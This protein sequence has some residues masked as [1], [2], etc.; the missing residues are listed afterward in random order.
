MSPGTV[1]SSISTAIGALLLVGVGASSAPAQTATASTPDIPAISLR[2]GLAGATGIE[3]VVITVGRSTVLQ[4]PFDVGRVALTNP[5][6]ADATVVNPRS[7]LLDGKTPGTIS[8]IL[9]GIDDSDKLQYDLV[10]EPVMSS[11]QERLRQ[12][13]PGEDITV[14][15]NNEAII[16]SGTVSSHAVS[17][18]I[19]EV[20]AATSAKSKVV[21]LLQA[22]GGAGSQQVMLQVRFAEVDRRATQDL[23]VNLFTGL[24]GYKNWVGRSTTGQFAAPGVGTGAT[25]G[26][27]SVGSLTFSDFL[28]LFVFNTKYNMGAVIRALQTKGYFQSLA[29]PNLIAYNNQEASFLAGGEIPVPVVQGLTNAVTVEWKE[30]GVRLRFKPTIVGDT[31][32]LHVAPEVSS[33]DFQNGIVINSFRIPAISSRKA[34]TEIEL[35]DGQSFAIAGL[36]DQVMQDEIEKVPGLGHIPILGYLFQ[37][38][39]LRKDHTELLVLITPHLVRPLNSDELPALPGDPAKFMQP[40]VGTPGGTV[41][42]DAGLA[43]PPDV[44][45]QITDTKAKKPGGGR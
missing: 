26:T 29:E 30:F 1:R 25:G 33:L 31:I 12:L 7:V 14:T 6:I 23:G 22:P 40:K 41:K 36:I 4:T 45:P 9:W 15:T 2:T 11:L 28:N 43:E 27:S 39:A 44:T 24:E 32:R 16:L 38:R 10:V 18:H 13:F 34:E 21:N 17:T 37:S 35:K 19:G 8:L 3:R 20:A 5:A 42:D